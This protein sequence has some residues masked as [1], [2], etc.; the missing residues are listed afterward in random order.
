M[1]ALGEAVVWGKPA[2]GGEIVITL[3]DGRGSG[4][5]LGVEAD[6]GLVEAGAG[7]PPGG[8]EPAQPAMAAVT[9]T[10]EKTVL[11]DIRPPVRELNA[12]DVRPSTHRE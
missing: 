2:A 5:A 7:E 8:W 1:V 12:D 4:L 6:A 10:T 11:A 9:A 3:G